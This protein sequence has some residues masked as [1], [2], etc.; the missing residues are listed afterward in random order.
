MKLLGI[1]QAAD[2][3]IG[4]EIKR[5]MTEASVRLSLGSPL[6]VLVGWKLC[7]RAPC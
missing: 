7:Q 3:L 2:E 1:A 6:H 4:D 5:F